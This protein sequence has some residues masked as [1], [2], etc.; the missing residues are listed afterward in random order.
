MS[1]KESG[2]YKSRLREMV[3]ILRKYEITRGLT[4]EK[5][6]LILED[7]GPTYIK[8]GQIMSMHSDILPKKYCDELMKLR[9]DVKP[10]PFS[11]VS[12]VIED[13][14]GCAW[15]PIFKEISEKP[16]GSASIAQVH[17]AVLKDGSP[18]VI[19][20]QRRGI[21]EM[22]ARDIALLRKAAKLIPSATIKGM[23]DIDMVLNELWDVTREEMNFLTEAA[24][25]EEFAKKNEGI[26]FVGTPVLYQEYT[27]LHVLVMEYIDGFEVDDKTAL[28][29]N[30]YDLKEIGSKLADNYMKQIIEDG[31]FHADPHPGNLRI[32]DGKI[33][34]IDMGMMGR[35]TERD[36]E[37]IAKA[38][39][40][41][42][43]ND[44]GMIQDAVMI[45]GEF[46][47]PPDPSRLYEDINNLLSKYGR[48]DMG[49]IDVA[50]ITMDL[51]DVMKENGIIMPHGLTMLARGLTHM[52]GVLAEISPEINMVEIAAGRIKESLLKNF[53]WKKE[54]KSSGKSFYRAFHRALDIPTLVADAV[55]GYLK[56]QTRVNLDLHASTELSRLLRRMVQNIVMGLWVM[57]LLIS[58]SIICTT[59]MKPK[60]WGIPALGAL[61]YLIAFGIVMYV[62]IKHLFSKK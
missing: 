25:M 56:G 17:R 23:V 61:G 58:S 40:G 28:L 19:K 42:A 53:D 8:I 10:M 5:L 55:Q 45:L 59:D 54:L 60:I 30:G 3:D 9:S 51:M 2:E 26:S 15:G 1:K 16:L 22:M 44:I 52:E 14:Y 57:A 39:R 48:V 46:K 12:D 24:N 33:I 7:L 35:L 13:S 38:V 50:A 32:R 11:E 6:R 29:E 18:V 37:Q 34:W 31:F 20:V 4:P 47:E 21:Y 27:T 62:F 49:N 36:R 41:V 43:A